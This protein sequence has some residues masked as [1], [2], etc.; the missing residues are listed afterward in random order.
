MRLRDCL[1]DTLG[2]ICSRFDADPCATRTV[3][4][5]GVGEVRV[6]KK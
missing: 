2:V 4:S 1:G 5:E 3:R 6:C